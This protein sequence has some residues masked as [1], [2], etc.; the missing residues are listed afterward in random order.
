MEIKD[1]A[2]R[3]IGREGIGLDPAG[4]LKEAEEVRLK[5]L[6]QDRL[7]GCVLVQGDNR[8]GRLAK[9]E[10][11]AGADFPDAGRGQLMEIGLQRP[12]IRIK[13]Q[14]KENGKVG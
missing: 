14:R 12:K 8:L 5:P 10:G 4:S 9:F 3:G 11:Q 6:V 13:T 2:G 1:D 7:I